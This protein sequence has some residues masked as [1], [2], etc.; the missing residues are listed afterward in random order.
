M[1]C[2]LSNLKTLKWAKNSN[3]KSTSNVL[4]Q[5]NYFRDAV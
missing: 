1:F 2:S 5:W 4:K 3:L